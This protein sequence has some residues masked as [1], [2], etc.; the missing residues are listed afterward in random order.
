MSIDKL[1]QLGSNVNQM[2]SLKK[3]EP[4]LQK[5]LVMCTQ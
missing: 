1:R 4:D 2:I 3:A 5:Y